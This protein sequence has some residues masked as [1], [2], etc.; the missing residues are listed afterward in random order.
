MSG[1]L[2]V[3]RAEIARL[4]RS[5]LAWLT[6]AVGEGVMA[7]YFLLLVVEYIDRES[8]QGA[9]GV[10]V[11]I[12]MRY[13]QT[14]QLTVLVLAP[15]LS[16]NAL[17]L[18][19]RDG[20][21]RYLFTTPLSISAITAGKFAGVLCLA[22]GYLLFIALMPLTLLWGAPIDLGIWFSN[23]LGLVL[24]ASFHVALGL[25]ASALVSAPAGAALL[26]LTASAVLWALD[27]AH[28]LDPQ[29]ALGGWSTLT[30]L[31]GFTHGLVGGGSVAYF[32]VG[33][34]ALLLLAMLVLGTERRL[35]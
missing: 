26:A 5:P 11:M 22:A 18:D 25:F 24:F 8:D 2:A 14:A 34:L 30:R 3:A 1:F 31:R 13:F 32:V 15:L 35:T 4:F 33:C 23:V 17:A 29:A 6:L 21:L 10:T 12:V 19:R 27:W 20:I 9:A 7:I 16:M 28:G